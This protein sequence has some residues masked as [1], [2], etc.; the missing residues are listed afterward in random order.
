M[1]T[2][3]RGDDLPVSLKGK[4]V[5]PRE[6]VVDSFRCVPADTDNAMRPVYRFTGPT[7][8]SVLVDC[9]RMDMA[10]QAAHL[11]T[12]L[13]NAAS[14]GDALVLPH[15]L[16]PFLRDFLQLW[17]S[18]AS[19]LSTLAAT[20]L[21]S[22]SRWQSLYKTILHHFVHRYIGQK[23]EI[24]N[25]SL[26]RLPARCYDY[27]HDCPSLNAFLRDPDQGETIFIVGANR[28]GHIETQVRD[29]DVSAREIPNPNAVARIKTALLVTKTN[30]SAIRQ[31]QQWLER[32]QWAMEW[33]MGPTHQEI[34]RTMLGA[35]Y[36]DAISAF[37]NS[38][39]DH[40]PT[41]GLEATALR[42]ADGNAPP[43]PSPVGA[44]PGYE[45]LGPG[46]GSKR[47][48]SRAAIG[49]ENDPV[50]LE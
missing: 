47:K 9:I 4:L 1:E 43:R 34:M 23:P 8:A 31:R 2:I 33:V 29:R 39:S 16:I 35:A 44:A 26:A 41:L 30:A 36:Y 11:E 10:P 19:V 21:G 7:I 45:P 6:A 3:P 32:K 50:V 22:Q 15:I 38:S 42:E 37:M 48:A 24:Q 5:R 12:E 18:S 49:T 27:C 25:P 17:T 28:R 46:A 20:Q 40:L 14:G 13:I